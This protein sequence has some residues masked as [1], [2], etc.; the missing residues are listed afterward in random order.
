MIPQTMLMSNIAVIITDIIAL[1][2][3]LTYKITVTL[4]KFQT[5]PI[6]VS[7]CTTIHSTSLTLLLLFM[8]LLLFAINSIQF[9][10]SDMH[11]PTFGEQEKV[12]DNNAGPI[13]TQ[14]E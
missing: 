3:S 5:L 2:V 1:S 4:P 9:P 11:S 8:R 7:V 14:L 6:S 13:A 12:R 10:F